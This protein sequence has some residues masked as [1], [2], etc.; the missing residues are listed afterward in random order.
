LSIIKKTDQPGVQSKT[1]LASFRNVIRIDESI[2]ERLKP[3]VSMDS[4]RLV[5]S[6]PAPIITRAAD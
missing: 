2:F 3:N 4:K 6:C 1:F 5:P